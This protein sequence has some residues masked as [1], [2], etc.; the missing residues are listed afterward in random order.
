MSNTG[1]GTY[2]EIAAWADASHSIGA[3]M[4]RYFFH[5]QKA[6]EAVDEEGLDLPD[7]QAALKEAVASAREL[8]AEAIRAG[9]DLRPERIVIADATGR[10]VATV[11]MKDVLPG[12]LLR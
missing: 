3:L 12:S 10:E 7:E 6:N 9:R 2:N 8:L 4:P 11:N 5:L 1:P